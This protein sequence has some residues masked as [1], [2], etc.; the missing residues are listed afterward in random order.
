[1][2]D[3]HRTLVYADAIN[4]IGEDIRALERKAEDLFNA[5]RDIGE[6]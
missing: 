6:L 3:T 4:L 1:M 5:C 2:N